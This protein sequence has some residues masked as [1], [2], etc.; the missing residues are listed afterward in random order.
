[1]GLLTSVIAFVGMVYAVWAKFY[2]D[3]IVPG[4][5]SVLA[6]ISFLFG[7]LFIMLGIIGDYIG[8][9]LSEVKARPRFLISDTTSDNQPE[10]QVDEQA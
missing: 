2:A 4:W 3:I 1:M 9:I 7:V 8:R 10:A 5:A 6:I